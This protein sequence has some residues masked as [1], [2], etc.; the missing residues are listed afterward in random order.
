MVLNHRLFFYLLLIPV[1]FSCGEKAHRREIPTAEKPVQITLRRLEKD[2]KRIS[3]ASDTAI[4]AEIR[5][6][7]PVF[8]EIYNTSVLNIGPSKSPMYLFRLLDFLQDKNI[9]AVFASCDSVYP[10][11]VMEVLGKQFS[12]AFTRYHTI[13]PQKPVPVVNTFVSGFN[14]GIIASDSTLALGLDMFL[15][16]NS[17]YYRLL[18]YPAY[19]VRQ[20][21]PA[22]LPVFALLAWLDHEWFDGFDPQNFI[23]EMVHKGKLQYFAEHLLPETADS[24]LFGISAKQLD[25][26]RAHEN[27]V[28]LSWIDKK[29]MFNSQASEFM[30]NFA[31]GP[32]T[33][34][35]PRESPAGLGTYMGYRL[36][37]TYMKNHPEVQ[38]SE[39]MKIPAQKVF[40]DAKF[41]PS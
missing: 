8:F 5:K 17:R 34:G 9:A 26:C 22:N 2:L 25:W 11:P 39:L 3:H 29:M 24:T 20:M 41:L 23:D 35:F 38:L 32:F 15:G 18:N 37:C 28:W 6:K 19:K 33:P 21:N 1:L 36:V 16:S 14:Y 12:D 4:L 7:Y 30:R 27:E 10:S 40:R 13:F 31:E